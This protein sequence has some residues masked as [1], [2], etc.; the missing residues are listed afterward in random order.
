MTPGPTKEHPI[1]ATSSRIAY[2]NPWIQVREDETLR[3]GGVKGIY[4]VVETNDSVVTCALNEQ[5]QCY[6]IYGYSYPTDTWSW[7]VP[8]GG[9]DGGEDMVAAAG[10]ELTE[11][12]GIVAGELKL[13]GSLIVSCGLLKERM[14]VV[15]GRD[16][17][18]GERPVAD[19]SDSISKGAFYSLADLQEMIMQGEICDAQSIAAIYMVE[20]WLEGQR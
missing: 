14:A 20:K 18:I 8:G 7:Q 4:G 2:E 3:T 12:T 5:D 11:E 9:S 13:L 15:V 10:R 6:L 16:L 1:I 17:S 19:D